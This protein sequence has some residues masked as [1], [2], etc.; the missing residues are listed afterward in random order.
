MYEIY[1]KII[2]SKF[3]PKIAIGHDKDGKI[4]LFKKLFPNKISVAYQFGYIFENYLSKEYKKISNK[5]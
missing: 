2:I 4:F 1:L 5:K 3:D